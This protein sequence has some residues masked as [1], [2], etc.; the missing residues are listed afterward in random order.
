MDVNDRDVHD[1]DGG[2]HPYNIFWNGSQMHFFW[3]EHCIALL[4]VGM[5]YRCIGIQIAGSAKQAIDYVLHAIP[6]AI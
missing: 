4:G 2:V 5:L 1:D 6:S 3:E